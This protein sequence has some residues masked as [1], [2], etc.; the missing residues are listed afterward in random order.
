VISAC[1]RA[2]GDYRIS[3]FVAGV[4]G[5]RVPP[6]HL[7]VLQNNFPIV[8]GSWCRLSNPPAGSRSISV[9]TYTF[10][11][12]PPL[13]F[14]SSP[15]RHL[16]LTLKIPLAGLPRGFAP[17]KPEIQFAPRKLLL[18][19]VQCLRKTREKR[20]PANEEKNKRI[21]GGGIRGDDSCDFG[22]RLF[23]W[24]ESEASVYFSENCRQR[25]LRCDTGG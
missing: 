20:Q 17:S 25:H 15:S 18:K 12:R 19:D 4:G 10:F 22:N 2:P 11:R 24:N 13:R 23:C 8:A 9:T 3:R 14:E 7:S 16:E 6:K 21:I 5:V 1:K